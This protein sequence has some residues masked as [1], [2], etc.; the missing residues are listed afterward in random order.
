[1]ARIE[2]QATTISWIPS[3]SIPGFM[4]RTPF[5]KGI[6]HFHPPPPLVL[7]DLNGMQ[8]RG[9]FRFANQLDAWVEVEAGEIRD[10]GYSGT[11]LT[12]GLTPI[13]AGRFR[14]LLPTK[15]NPVIRH[16]PQVVAGEATFVQTAGGRPIFSV[17][18]PSLHRPF[19]LT[20]PFNI[21]TTIALTIR[22]DGQARQR[23][24]GASPFPRHWL[25]DGEGKLAEKATLTRN[26]VWI[27]TVFGRHT[28]WGG[29]NETPV[30][31][32]PE[33][34]LERSLSEQTMQ[35][36]ARP[37][38]RNLRPG[39][40]L[41]R[42]SE[43]ATT[44]AVVLDGDFEVSVDERVVGH[45]GPGTVV[46]ERASL[47]GGQRT[48]ALRATTDCRVAE[49]PADRFTPEVLGALALGH[50]REDAE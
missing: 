45:V 49:A 12:M 17:V 23:L 3:D 4:M 7:E 38:V 27:K 25:Y 39:E 22:T 2:R 13:S 42:Q 18:R 31:S 15:A 6:M 5:E 19:L 44:I 48:A 14:V 26:E 34:E 40:F 47:E 20:K 46:G 37:E 50:H 1:M 10:C 30:V 29:E 33:T 9:E 36:G 24:A 28:P 41:F 16:A 43:E 11:G 8:R 32:D 35:A 21:W